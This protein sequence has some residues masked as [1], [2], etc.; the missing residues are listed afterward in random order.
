[1][2]GERPGISVILA[3]FTWGSIQCLPVDKRNTNRLV[4]GKQFLEH[5]A[6]K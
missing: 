6:T 4:W 2:P 3:V 1:M 5:Q